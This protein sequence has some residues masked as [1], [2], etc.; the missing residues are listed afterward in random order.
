M[1]RHKNGNGKKSLIAEVSLDSVID[2]TSYVEGDSDIENCHIGDGSRIIDSALINSV[3]LASTVRSS[4][5]VG[6]RF[7]GSQVSVN[8]AKDSLF[9]D[10]SVDGD[11]KLVKCEM[12]RCSVRNLNARNC[13]LSWVRPIYPEDYQ[14]CVEFH[15]DFHGGYITRG[16]WNHPPEL[17]HFPNSKVTIVE[18][19][20]GYVNVNCTERRISDWIKRG[21]R[22]AKIYGLN[23]AELVAA[24]AFGEHLLAKHSLPVKL[25]SV[26]AV[27]STRRSVAASSAVDEEPVQSLPENEEQPF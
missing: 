17:L 20:R 10:S 25:T 3:S 14:G 13:R 21:P 18:S 24:V 6:C 11:S 22:F 9:V 4:I 8:L 23:H 1:F 2:R 7:V 27:V 5:G 26:A 12:I 16:V 19:V 15:T